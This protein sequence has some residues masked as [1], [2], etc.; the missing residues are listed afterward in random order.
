MELSKAPAGLQLPDPRVE[1]VVNL[2][3]K[4]RYLLLRATTLATAC[5][6]CVLLLSASVDDQMKARWHDESIQCLLAIACWSAWVLVFVWVFVRWRA[7]GRYAVMVER[8]LASDVLH[9]LI[10]L[11]PLLLAFSIG[12]NAVVPRPGTAGFQP[13]IAFNDMFK[14]LEVLFLFSTVGEPYDFPDDVSYG[15]H[16]DSDPFAAASDPYNVPWLVGV[17]RVLFFVFHFCFII[18]GPVLMCNLL[19]ASMASTYATV[20]AGAE[21]EWRLRF[22]RMVFHMELLEPR[23]S[24]RNMLKDEPFEFVVDEQD[25][26]SDPFHLI[27]KEAPPLKR[28][29][30]T[31]GVAKQWVGGLSKRYS[32]FGE[33]SVHLSK[34]QSSVSHMQR[35]LVSRSSAHSLWKMPAMI[36]R[37]SNNEGAKDSVGK[38]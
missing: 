9:Y 3:R 15:R 30:S 7:L 16:S 18:V 32:S 35:A 19:I 5:V 33:R 4:Q 6:A 38:D 8:M 34:R 25:S 26:A 11:S 29:T 14:T 1:L 27:R 28:G 10:V 23:E 31:A 2:L 21:L 13:G 17:S 20:E 37:M 12:M 22:S 36:A 24:Q